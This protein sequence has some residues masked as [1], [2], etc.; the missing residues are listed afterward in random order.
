MNKRKPSAQACLAEKVIDKGMCVTCGACVG[1]CP[2]FNYHDGNVVKMDNC[3]AEDGRCVTFCPQSGAMD[4]GDA[5]VGDTTFHGLGEY[6]K[7]VAARCPDV[8]MVVQ[9]GGVV[10]ALVAFALEKKIIK[11]AVLTDKGDGQAPCGRIVTDADDLSDFSGSRYSAA[12]PLAALN[13]AAETDASAI[14]VVGLPCQ[15]KA[16]YRR[17]HYLNQQEM[18]DQV[19]LTIGLF[20]TWALDYRK[21]NDYLARQ[22]LTGRILKCDIPPPPAETFRVYTE[23]GVTEF[24]LSHIRELIQKGCGLCEDMTS[25]LADVSVGAF[26]G[27]EEWNI[28]IIRT[29]TGE[30]LV[31]Q[32]VAEG[33]LVIEDFPEE[34]FGYLEKAAMN[35]QVR[36]TEARQ[37]LTEGEDRK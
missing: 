33:R 14:G 15:I 5:A 3:C 36:G 7:I 31:E 25:R 35:K 6:R 29:E 12:A 26:E 4:L 24:P 32:A 20:C 27:R 2:Y 11:R 10:T 9:N 30:S 23:K 21:L 1:L 8:R 19:V 17:H 16:L 22:G 18:A 28:L 13:R 37:R 34:N